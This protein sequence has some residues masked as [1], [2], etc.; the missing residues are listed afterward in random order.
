EETFAQML[1]T[2]KLSVELNLDWSSFSLYQATSKATVST[3]KNKDTSSRTSAIDF[4]PTKSSSSREL[5][6]DRSLPLGP[7]VFSLAKETIPSPALMNN[8]WLTFNILGNYI[9]NKNL[10]P[11]GDPVKFVK[12]VNALRISYPEN[13]YMALF[14]GLGQITLSNL[15]QGISDHATCVAILENSDSWRYRFDQFKLTNLVENFPMK[16]KDVYNIL[17][18]ITAK[19]KYKND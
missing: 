9:C 4:I 12:W 18:T 16:Q 3:N 10:A 13:P 19:Y 17:S 5:K 1:E 15:T 14:A 2:Y 11:E 8:I 6:E 7:D